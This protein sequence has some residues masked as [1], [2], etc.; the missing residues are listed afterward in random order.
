MTEPYSILVVGTLDTK[1][2]EIRFLRDRLVAA[3]LAATVVDIGV[4]AP[5][6]FPPDVPRD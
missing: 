1:G 5:P 6:A 2:N 4:L 3:G